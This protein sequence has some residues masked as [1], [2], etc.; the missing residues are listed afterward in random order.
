MNIEKFDPS[1]F[2]ESVKN[3]IKETF[4]GMIPEDEW[5]GLVEKEVKAFFDQPVKMEIT[6]ES[7]PPVGGAW[8]GSNYF[9]ATSEQTPFR[10]IVW[11]YCKEMTYE[12][13]KERINKEFFNNT[14]SPSEEDLSEKMREFI[15]ESAPHAM[16]AFFQQIILNQSAMFQSQIQGLRNGYG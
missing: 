15:K 14:W 11:E 6:K 13:L 10:A 7:A 8:Y 9:V 2:T 16:A 12:T 5:Q 4:V 3:R 1:K